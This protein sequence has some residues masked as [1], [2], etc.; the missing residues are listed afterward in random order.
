MCA[1]KI[2]GPRGN[3]YTVR[4]RWLPWRRKVDFSDA[5]VDF[6]GADDL[7]CLGLIVVII[8]I[9]FILIAVV[10]LVELLLLLLLL[11]LWLLI[12]ILLRRPWT[13]DVRRDRVLVHTEKVV[14]LRESSLRMRHLLDNAPRYW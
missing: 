5:P 4:R 2:R 8:A 6:G 3:T 13:I 12:R 14:G 7:G 1:V 9:P 11:P 10:A